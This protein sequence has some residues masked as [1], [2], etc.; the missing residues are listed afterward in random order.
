MKEHIFI[1]ALIMWTLDVSYFLL[2]IV[3]FCPIVS[4]ICFMAVP[5]LLELSRKDYHNFVL[6][7]AP[8]FIHKSKR[9]SLRLITVSCSTSGEVPQ[10]LT[11]VC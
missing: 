5:W 3:S 10:R 11:C 2:L 8:H 6:L 4:L 9:Q 7:H 1:P